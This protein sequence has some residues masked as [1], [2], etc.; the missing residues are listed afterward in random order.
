MSLR[1]I[2]I[3]GFILFAFGNCKKSEFVSEKTKNDVFEDSKISIDKA[4][5]LL[6]SRSSNINII[7]N[8]TPSN[9]SLL[10]FTKAPDWSKVQIYNVGDEMVMEVFLSFNKKTAYSLQK[11]SSTNQKKEDRSISYLVFSKNP[12]QI[13]D[14]AI[15]TIIPDITYLEIPGKKITNNHYKNIDKDFSGIVLFHTWDN[16]F[17]VGW[18]YEKGNIIQEI[19]SEKNAEVKTNF[20]EIQPDL[21]D[22]CETTIITTYCA[23][24][25]SWYVNGV[26][27]F[28]SCGGAY[29]CDQYSYSSCNRSNGSITNDPGGYGSSTSFTVTPSDGNVDGALN[30]CENSFAFQNK[31]QATSNG[32]GWQVAAV[33]DIHMDIVDTQTGNFVN[34][35][36]PVIYFGLPIIRLN[37]DFYSNERAAEISAAAVEFAER[38]VMKYYHSLGGSLDRV[39]MGVYYKKK[40]NDFMGTFGGSASQYASGYTVPVKIAKYNGILGL[41]CY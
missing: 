26:Y 34:L 1:R 9:K 22:D 29:V 33:K 17:I 16:D 11:L 19:E 7:E 21:A 36:L 2:F 32:E 28:T 18:K 24:C 39:G 3:F 27:S 13:I 30:I 31:I 35:T 25:T 40:I 6:S 5:E 8:N 14:Y 15:M 4:K 41:G 23:D 20:N 38:E 12:R 37:G 10:P